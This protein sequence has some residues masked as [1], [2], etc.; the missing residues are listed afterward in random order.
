MG[1]RDLTSPV[2]EVRF[3]FYVLNCSVYPINIDDSREGNVQFV[4]TD[5][6]E[7]MRIESNV[8]ELPHAG[9]Q[10]FTVR[11]RISKGEFELIRDASDDLYFRF[12]KVVVMVKGVK[13]FPDV[14]PK[15]LYLN[16]W[17]VTKKGELRK[18]H[19]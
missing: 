17:I 14:V 1:T 3:S 2:G 16:E 13:D 5:L 11:Q 18:F 19:N 6:L 15:R 12:D 4:T 7:P 9:T 8:K 10:F